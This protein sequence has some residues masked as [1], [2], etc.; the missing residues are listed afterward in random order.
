MKKTNKKK[1]ITLA[2]IGVFTI[3]GGTLAYFTTNTSIANVFKIAK[4]ESQIVETFESPSAW[5]PGTTTPK[6]VTIK[7]NGNISMAVR[8]S[9]EEKWV[10]ENGNDIALSDSNGNVASVINFNNGWEKNDDGYYY[11]GSKSNLTK[12][13]PTETSSSFINSVT[14]NNKITASL[15]KSESSD[16]KIVTYESTGDSYDGAKYTLTIK[17]DTIQ[18]DQASNVW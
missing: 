15:K 6:T 16:G 13:N 18:Y 8:V 1:L 12:L 9:Y 17:I 11:Y 5:T 3:L 14:F 4:Y 10:N 7:N 2:G